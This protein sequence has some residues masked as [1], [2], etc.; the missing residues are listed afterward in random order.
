[1]LAPACAQASAARTPSPAQSLR[2]LVA[3]VFL[4][5]LFFALGLLLFQLVLDAG[6]LLLWFRKR[7]SL[8]R[9]RFKNGE[10]VELPPVSEK[11]FAHLPG[12]E[13]SASFHLFLSRELPL[14]GTAQKCGPRTLFHTLCSIL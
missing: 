7:Q 1:M 9:L 2:K 10:F 5:F 14:L 12:L 11:D 3:G 13:A 6:S 8:Y 4:F